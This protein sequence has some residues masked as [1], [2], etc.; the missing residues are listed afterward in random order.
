MP[1][2]SAGIL[3]YRLRNK[4][5]EVLLVH[6][7]GPFWA[8]K[9]EGVWSIPKGEIE[10]NENPFAAAIRETAEETGLDLRTINTSSFIELSPV[11][12]KSGK[13]IFIW[14]IEADF[15]TDEIKSNSFEME[16]PPKSGQRKQFP[17]VDK[18][19]WFPIE[20][21]KVKVN[22]GQIAVLEELADKIKMKSET[23]IEK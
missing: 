15:D 10:E 18:A 17:E 13:L 4:I 2:R 14:G 21:A 5:P 7:G 1:N 22:K 6:P 8:K 12:I 9:D 23:K 19:E 20:K 11:K 16:W 3:L